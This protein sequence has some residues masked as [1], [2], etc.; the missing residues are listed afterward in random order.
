ME[1]GNFNLERKVLI[2]AEIGNN[3]EGNFTLAQELIGLAKEAGADAVKFQTFK[4]EYISGVDSKRLK[5]L[6]GFQF[7][8]SQFQ[9][10]VTQAS[11][12]GIIFF[13][14]PFDLMSAEF[15]NKIQPVF[16]IASSD[17]D[18][19]QLI[20]KIAGFKKPMIVST[21]LANLKL[22]DRVR[23]CVCKIWSQY[24]T[25]PGLALLHCVSS[26]PTPPGQ[27]NLGAITSMKTR[28]P[29][30]VIGYSDH[31]LGIQAAI[32][33]V[34][35]GAKIVEKHFTLDK[36]YSDFQDHQLSATPIELKK[37]V[38]SAVGAANGDVSLA[39]KQ[40]GVDVEFVEDLLK[41]T[42]R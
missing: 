35:L 17:N 7:S 1:I 22:L 15:L 12:L 36:N 5:R 13:S 31:T 21:G 30:L 2:V 33:S 29:E 16:K 11:N 20:R 27:A 25:N 18:N 14:T 34:V 24:N 39:A 6:Q 23:D 37:M 10:L 8:H 42:I 28:Y 26:Y 41:R 9:K 19:F 3:H 4:P 32:S 40:M 38:E